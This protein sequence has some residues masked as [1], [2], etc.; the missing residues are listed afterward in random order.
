MPGWRR[1]LSAWALALIFAV[2]GF[3]VVELA[4]SFGLAKARPELHGVRIPQ[5]DP[6]DLGSP[7][8]DDA[9]AELEARRAFME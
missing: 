6:F 1:V 9:A 3:A 8:S 5:S 4:P 7:F 2:A